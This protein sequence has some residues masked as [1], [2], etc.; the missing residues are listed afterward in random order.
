MRGGAGRWGGDGGGGLGGGPSGHRA[1][2]GGL[3]LPPCDSGT[4]G[5]GGWGG[6]VGHRAGWDPPH[7]TPPHGTPPPNTPGC[8]P[9]CGPTTSPM[10]GLGG[11][12]LPG[13]H[14]YLH[15]NGVTSGLGSGWFGDPSSSVRCGRHPELPRDPQPPPPRTPNPLTLPPPPLPGPPSLQPCTEPH[16]SISVG[17]G[18]AG[19]WSS[20]SKGL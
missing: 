19:G 9:H 15:A 13:P 1:L 16:H 3:R 17:G 6:V 11:G 18:C 7:G 12:G 5:F 8:Q 20:C 14:S 2:R 4:N 10:G